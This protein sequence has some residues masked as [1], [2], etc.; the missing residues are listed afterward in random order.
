[1]NLE[2]RPQNRKEESAPN[3]KNKILYSVNLAG[4][5]SVRKVKD[6]LYQYQTWQA[7]KQKKE[8]WFA[9]KQKGLREGMLPK[10]CAETIAAI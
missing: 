6:I 2:N 7:L 5:S 1:M 10:V 3:I 9:S 8:H 4:V